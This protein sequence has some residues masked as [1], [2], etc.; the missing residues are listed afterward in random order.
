MFL[1]YL[2]FR[3]NTFFVFT[4]RIDT[5]GACYSRALQ[6]LLTGVYISALCLIGIFGTRTAWGPFVLMIVFLV[7]TVLIHISLNAVLSPLETSLPADI[8][9]DDEHEAI[10]ALEDGADRRHYRAPDHQHQ[11]R[12][13]NRQLHPQSQNGSHIRSGGEAYGS[14]PAHDIN[15]N[16]TT[17]TNFSH[18]GTNEERSRAQPEY[19]TTKTPARQTQHHNQPQ[20]PPKAGFLKR[21]LKPHVYASYHALRPL[22]Y[23]P[24]KSNRAL[25][26]YTRAQVFEAY[27][28]PAI[29]S[30]P[31]VIW[32]VHD[33]M[34]ISRS[35]IAEAQRVGIQ[36]SDASAGLDAKNRVVWGGDR[37]GGEGKE[38]QG[39]RKASETVPIWKGN[40]IW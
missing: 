32:I 16:T 25:P 7:G 40:V 29:V 13:E 9:A 26:I 24:F 18:P 28:H 10:R 34:G 8:Q 35:E 5:R 27:L 31:P 2:A 36:M 17:A 1:L 21:F 3:Y 30:P 20:T 11:H 39:S 38:G 19:S 23:D 14:S 33:Q 6:Q 22:V 37:E 15:T 4:T 12:S